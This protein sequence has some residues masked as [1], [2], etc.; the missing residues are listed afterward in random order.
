MATKKKKKPTYPS[1]PRTIY[2]SEYPP[3]SIDYNPNDPLTVYPTDTLSWQGNAHAVRIEFPKGKSPFVKGSPVIL[4]AAPGYPT[5]PYT[6]RKA[7]I[8]K[9]FKYTAMISDG[10]SII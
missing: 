10:S 1:T 2:V 6:I 8:K 3:G 4:S 5:T 7:G 9:K